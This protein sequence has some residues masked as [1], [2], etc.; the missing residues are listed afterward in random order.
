MA[1]RS[2]TPSG[3]RTANRFISPA[4]HQEAISQEQGNCKA[5]QPRSSEKNAASRAG[6]TPC[7][8][9][10]VG[11]YY[12]RALKSVTAEDRAFEEKARLDAALSS[13]GTDGACAHASCLLLDM[14]YA[15]P[16]MDRH[17]IDLDPTICGGGRS[18]TAERRD[19]RSTAAEGRDRPKVTNDG[20][21]RPASGSG[22][23]EPAEHEPVQ[24]RRQF[25]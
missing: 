23:V 4:R 3:G 9:W 6:Q 2:I 15:S 19:P 7:A 12:T 5:A 16:D 22:R 11:I 20:V 13:E 1:L 24:K 14:D 8:R 10:A 21:R 25:G 17:C 18:P